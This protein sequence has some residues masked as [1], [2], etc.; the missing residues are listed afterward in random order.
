MIRRLLS[1]LLLAALLAPSSGYASAVQVEMLLGGLAASGVPLSGGKVYTYAAGDFT[2]AP[3]WSN[4]TKT[5][6]N[7][8]GRAH[9]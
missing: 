4:S 7:K 1:A 2:P 8:I 5:A 6:T 9:V 3:T